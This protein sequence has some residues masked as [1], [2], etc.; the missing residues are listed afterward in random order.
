MSSATFDLLHPQVQKAVWSMGWKEFHPI[1]V[2]AIHQVLEHP[3]HL[4]ITAQT[5]GGKRKLP[6]CQSFP[7]WLRIHNHQSKHFTLGH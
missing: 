1:Q 5:A 3:G 7:N 4:I 2:K 6:S